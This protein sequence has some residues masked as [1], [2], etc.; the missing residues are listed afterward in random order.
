MV[1]DKD[2]KQKILQV[3]N[4]YQIPGGEDTVV[5]NEKKLLEDHGHEV[6]QYSRNNSELKEFSK[7]RKLL[8]PFTTIFNPRTYKEVKRIIREQDID[9]VHVHNILNLIS[10]A[11]YYV[12]LSC[13][14][15]VVQTVHNFRLLCPGATFYRNGHICEDCVSK[16]LGCAVKHGCYRGSKV[17]TLVC[18]VNTWVHR[19]TG[20]YGKLNYICLTEFNKEKLLSLKQIKAEQVFIKPNFVVNKI[21]TIPYEERPNQY[22]FAGRLDKLKG[23]DILFEAWKLMGDSAPV[24]IVCGTGPMEDWCR[25]FIANNKISNIEMRGFVPNNEAEK[26]IAN[27]KALILPTQ[28]Y[29]GFPMTIVEAYSVGTPVIGSDLGNTGSVV[30]EGSTGMKFEY[31]SC[32]SLIEA[33]RRISNCGSGISSTTKTTY[34]EK[35]SDEQNYQVL[36]SIYKKAVIK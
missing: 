24:L 17:Q 2:K 23:I 1:M 8:L 25:D 12:A 35:Y 30:E 6:V 16:G 36:E 27:S 19:L 26:L 20:V 11:V 33:V 15:P 28:W 4:Y 29:E 21:A 31:N 13:K 7:F 34:V 18:A 22:I 32:N 3:H 10:P 5:A 14:V 9:I